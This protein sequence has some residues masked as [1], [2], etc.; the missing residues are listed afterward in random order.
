MEDAVVPTEDDEDTDETVEAVVL[1]VTDDGCGGGCEGL[2]IG[3]GDR[4][5]SS[6]LF[7]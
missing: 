6:I 2:P 4:L 7:E 3:A 1:L 5:G